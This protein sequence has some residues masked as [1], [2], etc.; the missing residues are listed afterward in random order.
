MLPIEDSI[1]FE[2]WDKVKS[3]PKKQLCKYYGTP[4]LYAKWV[5]RFRSKGLWHCCKLKHLEQIE[6]RRRYIKQWRADN[7]E[8]TKHYVETYWLRK[9][10]KNGETAPIEAQAEDRIE[11]NVRPSKQELDLFF[12]KIQT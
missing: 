12:N 9:L 5:A 8:K 11:F 6:H 10:H 4:K 7:K 3:I 2:E 1:V